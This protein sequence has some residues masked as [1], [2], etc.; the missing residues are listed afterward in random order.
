MPEYSSPGQLI[1]F[2]G[3]DGVGKSTLAQ[4]LT[5]KLT[6]AGLPSEYLALPGNEMGTIGRLVYDIHHNPAV[7]GLGKLTPGSLQALHIAAHLDAI[8]RRILPAINRGSWVILDRF[9]WSTWVYGHM[10]AVD[11]ATLDALIQAEQFQWDGIKPTALFLIDRPSG[12]PSDDIRIQLRER[13]HA[14]AKREQGLY[15]IRLI[16]NDAAV[17]ESLRRMLAALQDITPLIRIASLKTLGRSAEQ[18]VEQPLLI[19]STKDR[20]FI[21]AKLSPARPTVVYESYWKFAAERQQVFFRKLEGL[22]APWTTDPILARHKFTNAYRASDRVSQYL[23]RHVIY[24]GDQSPEEVF[25]RT[26]CFRLFNKIETWNLLEAKLG[27]VSY[28]DYSFS[29]YDQVLAGALSSGTRIYSGAYIMPS[30]RTSFGYPQ[31]HRNNLRLLERMMD[32]EVPRRIA[33]A[34]NM[35]QAF[36]LLRSYPTVGNFLAYQF[37]T[38][39]NY[40]KS[41]RFLRDGI[42]GTRARRTG[43]HSQVLRRFGRLERVG[44]NPTRHGAPRVRI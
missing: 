2:E 39:L 22:S 26:I 3:P 32:G 16:A 44:R 36:E 38:D 17:D 31:K 18:R 21:P 34:S 1:V 37:V 4:A 11:G 33:D 5:R 7:Y 28:A 24:E 6:E 42:R 35:G 43:W 13:Y 9:W 25:F 14:L 10:S 15:P 30:G 41:H 40:S 12:S 8:E 19:P 27:T 20:T 29:R 23:I